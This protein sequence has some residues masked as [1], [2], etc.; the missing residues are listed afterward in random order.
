MTTGFAR[1]NLYFESRRALPSEKPRV[2]LDYV[3][4]EGDNA[5][6]VYFSTTKQVDETA[7]LL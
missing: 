7:R 4:R 2:L 5:G 3:L 6:I 1:P